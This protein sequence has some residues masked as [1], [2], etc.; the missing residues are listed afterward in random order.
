MAEA[1]TRTRALVFT[2]PNCEYSA[3][4]REEL[5]GKGTQF[6]EVDLSQNPDR[7][8]EV[9]ELSGGDRITPLMVAV[10]GTVEGRLDRGLTGCPAL[11]HL[12]DSSSARRVVA[13]RRTTKRVRSR[14]ERRMFCMVAPL[15]SD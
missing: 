12:G 7:W 13:T 6:D 4:L 1:Q 11:G 8:D 10:D 14:R 9:V 15:D 2:H 3:M 5:T